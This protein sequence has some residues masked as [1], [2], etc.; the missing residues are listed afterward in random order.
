MT[1]QVKQ[2]FTLKISQANRT[3]M[4]VIIYDML[5][6][7]VKEAEIGFSEGNIEEFLRSVRSAKECNK[8]LMISLDF[9]YDIASMLLQLYVYVNKELTSAEIYKRN[10]HLEIVTTIMT[11]LQEA[12]FKVAKEDISKPV[13][14]N[15]QTVYAGLTYGK[16]DLVENISL[17]NNRGFLA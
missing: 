5:L 13:M 2:E 8:E 4:I 9:E 12:Y 3:Q 16:N 14:D 1:D 7:Y 15:I 6:V 11:G 17:G 10:S